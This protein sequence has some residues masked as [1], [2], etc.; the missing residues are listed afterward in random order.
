MYYNKNSRVQIISTDKSGEYKKCIG[1]YG[2][3]KKGGISQISVQVDNKYNSSSGK[4][5]FWF[6]SRQLK[7][8]DKYEENMNNESEENNMLDNKYNKVVF[9]K[10]V[11]RY[12][13]NKIRSFAY[14]GEDVIEGD[15]VLCDNATGYTLAKVEEVIT[16]EEAKE[17]N[18][19]PTKEI[20]C[21]CNM[22]DFNNRKEAR[23][24][25]KKLKADMDKRVQEIQKNEIYLLLAEKD[26]E[27]K[28]LLEEYNEIL[29]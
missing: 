12:E 27:L 19:I 6:D 7:L 18:H 20:I 21:K 26:P 15:Y 5:L 23:E 2:T 10:F 14:Y 29:R 28:K 25:A 24:K 22:N 3:V 11:D 17:K 1:L 4:G 8:I 9:V 16:K 13:D